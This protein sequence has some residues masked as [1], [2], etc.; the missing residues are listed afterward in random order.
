MCV[1]HYF[2]HSLFFYVKSTW[3]YHAS[4]L[5]KIHSFGAF[6]NGITIITHSYPWF[7]CFFSDTHKFGCQLFQFFGFSFCK[8]EV[9]SKK[10]SSNNHIFGD[11]WL[12]DSA[13]YFSLPNKRG[14][15]NNRL[16]L[17]NLLKSYPFIR[18]HLIKHITNCLWV[19]KKISLRINVHGCLLGRLEYYNYILQIHPSNT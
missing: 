19:E 11:F 13:T 17:E 14:G 7:R 1:F 12:V 3:I 9:F 6:F 10:N 4:F 8:R 15:A 5:T 2:M 18:S 16:W